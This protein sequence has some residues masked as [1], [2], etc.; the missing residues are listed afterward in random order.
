MPSLRNNVTRM[1]DQ[2]GIAYTAYA[3]PAQKL[4]AQETA[5]LLGVPPMQVFKTLVVVRPMGGKPILALIPGP[6]RLD[7]KALA[8]L[9]GVKK[10]RLATQREAEAL[11]GLPTG[12]ISPLALRGRGFQVWLDGHARHFTAIHLSGGQW[13]LNLRLAVEDVARLCQA[14]WGAFSHSVSG[15]A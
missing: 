15:A 6:H 4:S 11:T 10:L 9:A 2:L 3:L 8:R 13:G 1:L 7:L 12:A 5:R 14:R